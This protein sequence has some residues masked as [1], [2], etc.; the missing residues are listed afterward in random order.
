MLPCIYI[1]SP[2]TWEE[3]YRQNFGELTALPRKGRLDLA[4][5]SLA[6]MEPRNQETTEK[7]G[8]EV[9]RRM[10]MRE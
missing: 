2:F 3:G 1:L 10:K 7:E 8:V 5:F 4:D 9:G 6:D